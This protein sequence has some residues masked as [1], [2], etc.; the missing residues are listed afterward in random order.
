MRSSTAR[1]CSALVAGGLLA[2]CGGGGSGG[3]RVVAVPGGSAESAPIWFEEVALASGLDFTHAAFHEQRF[4]MP[5]ISPGGVGLID[6]DG[7]G[8]LDV[9]CV[10]SGDPAAD[11]IDSG[12][13]RLFRNVGGGSF[14]EVAGAAGADDTGYGHGC[15]VGDYDGD[16]DADLYVTNL[17]ANV[18]YR[19]DG[20]RFTDVTA[21]SGTAVENW[22]TACSFVDYDADGD[23]DLF[24][25]N[26]LN[27][28][29]DIELVC[30]SG[31]SERDYCSP[32]NYNL[33]SVDRLF[34]ND[35][36]GRFTEVTEEA[37]LGAGTGI[38]LGVALADFDGD[39]SVD[40]YVANDSVPNLLWMNDGKGRFTN[41]ALLLG[42]AV[43]GSGASEAGMGVQAVDVENDG[44]WDLYMTH[45][46]DETNTFYRNQG[47]SF[48]DT[49]AATGL[50][51][52]SRRMTGFGMGFADFD[53]DGVVDLWVANGRV[54]LWRPYPNP[55]R[56]YA[57]PNQLFAGLGDG[58]FEEIAGGGVA[59]VPMGT[60]RAAAL[61]DLD[62][63]GDLD[64]V[65]LDWNGPLRLLRNV[66]PRAG[67]WIGLR[68]VDAAGA[69]VLGAVVRVDTAGG[70]HYRQS[71]TSYSY[72]AASDPRVHFGLGQSERVD[73]VL[74][75]WPDGTEESFG[76]LAG[77]R[78]HELGWGGGEQR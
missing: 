77:G 60:S 72:C 51:G 65:Y 4:W 8:L 38:G 36:G 1:T 78:Y 19:N 46:R 30:R 71:F 54:D 29:P 58:R 24:V 73:A 20:G 18:L 31:Q 11:A 74:V 52:P 49:T 5:E 27:W 41:R 3:K 9:Y 22:S 34:R 25:V 53:H 43:N 68:L 2:A 35:G 50:A 62:D 55:E 10:Q 59:D 42:C 7:D 15:A 40:F 75:R 28:S 26:N 23:L 69:D 56:P 32:A 48:S 57:E 12:P 21:E 47:G 37:G 64:I 16:G 63:D 44:D 70:S 39:G 6:F 76:P 17:R 33:P 61:G 45:V 67:G 66:A 14:E 13:N